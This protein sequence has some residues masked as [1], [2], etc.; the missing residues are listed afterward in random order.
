MTEFEQELLA[1]LDERMNILID[2][3]KGINRRLE[4]NYITE[5]RF[6]PVQQVVLGFAALILVAFGTAITTMVMR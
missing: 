5:D 6:K 1:R 4:E 2:E 3:V